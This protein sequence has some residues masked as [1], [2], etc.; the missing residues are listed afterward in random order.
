MKPSGVFA[1][2]LSVGR[3]RSIRSNRDAKDIRLTLAAV[4]G[5]IPRVLRECGAL[6]MLTLYSQQLSGNAYKPR[7]LMALLGI[8][9]RPVEV[10]TYDGSTR[11][12]EFLAKNPIGKVPLLEFE[13][14]RHLAESNAILLYLAEGTPY[15]P[16]EKFDR[17]KAYEWLFFEQ[18]VHEPAI[19][20]RRSILTAPSR[21]HLRT[22]ERL[23]DLLEKGNA[24]LA[25]REKRLS[26]ADWLAGD[27]YSVADIALYA[28]THVAGEGGYDLAAYPGI[29]AWLARVAAEPGHVPI[30][31][32]P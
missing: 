30:D 11:R 22:P 16:A 15:L 4:A 25:I 23:A 28:Y 12:P 17:G 13:D 19:A 27:G 6:P 32:V 20:V 21:A 7:L 5:E 14:G 3:D 1:Q 8:P 2:W 24:A 18:Y 9:F 31:W 29:T 26:D 10:N